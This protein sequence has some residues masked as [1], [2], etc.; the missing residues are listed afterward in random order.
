MNQKYRII[1]VHQTPETE[2]SALQ[3]LEDEVNTRLDKGWILIGGPQIAPETDQSY[4]TVI[5]AMLEP[6]P[7]PPIKA[8]GRKRAPLELDA[9]EIR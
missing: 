3:E 6:A 9:L 1:V 5:Q 7:I 8:V 2:E 4:A